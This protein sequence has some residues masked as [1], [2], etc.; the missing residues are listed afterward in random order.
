MSSAKRSTMTVVTS[1][2]ALVVFLFGGG[3]ITAYAASGSLPGDALY[4]VKTSLENARVSLTT[5]NSVKSSLLLDFAGLRLDEIKSLIANG[6]LD[7]VSQATSQFKSDIEH[8][9]EAIQQLAKS[10]P[11]HA[12]ELNAQAADILKGYGTALNEMLSNVPADVQPVIEDAMNT[13]Q[14]VTDSID[15]ANTNDNLNSNSNG[16]V[17]DNLN[18]NANDN[19]NSN[20]NLNGN[21][22]D[23]NSIDVVGV[24]DSI[25]G[26]Q[27]VIDGKTVIID[28]SIVIDGSFKVGDTIKIEGV[29]NPDGSFTVTRIEAINGSDVSVM[30]SFGDEN[31]NSNDSNSN[32]A[33]SDDKNGND[34]LNGNTN[35][36]TND[37]HGGNSN[38]NS[39]SSDGGN[40]NSSGGS[41]SGGSNSNGG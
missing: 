31:L 2:I 25:S 7:H 19:V 41:G 35:T 29:L 11:T 39:G 3:G 5:D 28:P 34:N 21:V 8:A 1:I 23:S 32:T 36:N 14:S 38:S 10:D 4:P 37:S 12:A 17:N 33:N 30:P 6:R 20:G 24:I 27:W 13:S 18:G 22:N 9:Q 16:N 40:S 26:N 15:N